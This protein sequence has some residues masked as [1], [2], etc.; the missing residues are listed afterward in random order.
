M[1]DEA[2][3]LS[4]I[5]ARSASPT[6][7]DYDAISEAFMETARGRWFLGEFAK[8]NRNADTA[9]V[10][11]AVTR[12]E[13]TI[14]AQK[15]SPSDDLNDTLAAVRAIV[16][17]AKT[18]VA[19]ALGDPA[20]DHIL[21]PHRKSARVIREIAWGLRES[22][23]DVRICDLLDGQVEAINTACDSFAAFPMREAALLAVDAA[24]ADIDRL[25]AGNI[26]PSGLADPAEADAAA[27]A[28]PDAT[29]AVAYELAPDEPAAPEIALEASAEAFEALPQQ[30][31][32]AP[33]IGSEVPE[34]LPEAPETGL[35]AAPK[36]MEPEPAEPE[37]ELTDALAAEIFEE[38]GV[39]EPPARHT[40]LA[41]VELMPVTEP[42]PAAELPGPADISLGASLIASG[43]VAKP[44]EPR[45]DPLAPIRRMSQAEKI[46]FF[47]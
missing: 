38:P 46:A 26:P 43:I 7:A 33:E 44:A 23:A 8:R 11:D 27:A 31:D 42:G 3:A 15:A 40:V 13:R 18:A 45:I 19:D 25:A 47:S 17:G 35:E 16:A 6:D 24:M 32:D 22:G 36:A 10:L 34:I 9:M 12:I 39:I 20:L 41:Q 1:A 4:P 2:F 37:T 29:E 14:A 30:S 28:A 21:A 5:S